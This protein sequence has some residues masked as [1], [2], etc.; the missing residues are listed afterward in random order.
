[1]ASSTQTV[2]QEAS[3]AE[4]PISITG[5]LNSGHSLRN[6]ERIAQE[7]Y[8]VTREDRADLFERDGQ[9]SSWP[10]MINKATEIN[11]NIGGLQASFRIGVVILLVLVLCIVSIARWPTSSSRTGSQPS[12]APSLDLSDISPVNASTTEDTKSSHTPVSLENKNNTVVDSS[13]SQLTQATSTF[14]PAI[15]GFSDGEVSQVLEKAIQDLRYPTDQNETIEELQ[16]L[17]RELIL[18]AHQQAVEERVQTLKKKVIRLI[19]WL[20][21]AVA[22]ADPILLVLFVSIRALLR[23]YWYPGFYTPGTDENEP[24]YSFSQQQ[25]SISPDLRRCIE[26][27]RSVSPELPE[28]EGPK[29]LDSVGSALLPL[30]VSPELL[31]SEGPELL[32]LSVSPKLLDPMGPRRRYTVRSAFGGSISWP[33]LVRILLQ[34]TYLGSAVYF[35]CKEQ[36]T[37]GDITIIAGCGMSLLLSALSRTS[38][39]STFWRIV[40]GLY[41]MLDHFCLRGVSRLPYLSDI[42]YPNRWTESRRR[43]TD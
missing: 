16:A 4:Q 39:A 23:L 8:P 33:F 36:R 26:V 14:S 2:V 20:S 38:A 15:T 35:L 11:L 43:S 22:I 29:L 3:V 12:D 41:D 6:Q 30:S 7:G 21:V 1:M 32:P 19:A 34:S 18:K 9:R 28:S 17:N 37:A 13:K 27:A 10:D 25:H 42:Y 31:E 40:S 5:T 24:N